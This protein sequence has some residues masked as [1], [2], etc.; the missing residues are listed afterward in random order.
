MLRYRNNFSYSCC[1]VFSRN[2]HH[3]IWQPINWWQTQY[4]TFNGTEEFRLF[5]ISRSNTIFENNLA[6]I[7]IFLVNVYHGFNFT[8]IDGGLGNTYIN[9]YVGNCTVFILEDN[10]LQY[11]WKN[12]KDYNWGNNKYILTYIT[13]HYLCVKTTSLDDKEMKYTYSRNHYKINGEW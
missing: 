4:I 10:S 11:L 3:M 12:A 6:L 8:L 7:N 9:N 2:F 5:C 13:V 1:H